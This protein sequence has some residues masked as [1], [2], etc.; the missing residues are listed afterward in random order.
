VGPT[1][2]HD[3]QNKQVTLSDA[4]HN[5]VLRLNYD[6]KCILDQVNVGGRQVVNGEVNST[7]GGGVFSAIKL[8]DEWFD[9]RMCISTPQISTTSNTV[10]VTGIR[11]GAAAMEVSETWRFTVESDRIVWRVDRTYETSGTMEDTCF[12]RWDF[13]SMSTWTGA[14]L[15]N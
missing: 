7:A 8:G 3:Q 5:L 6:G 11:F 4:G 13:L 14:L 10:S 15:G 1:V 2:E 9:S 12:P